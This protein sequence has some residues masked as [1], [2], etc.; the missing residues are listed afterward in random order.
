MYTE[1]QVM[2]PLRLSVRQL[3]LQAL[4]TATVLC[5]TVYANA[6]GTMVRME[7]HKLSDEL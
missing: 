4:A 3:S 2:I 1:K 6:C 5:G 7:H